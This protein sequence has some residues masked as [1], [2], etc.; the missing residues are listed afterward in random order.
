MYIYGYLKLTKTFSM[1]HITLFLKGFFIL[2][3]I[4][5]SALNAQNNKSIQFKSG[6]Y[7]P[8]TNINEIVNQVSYSADELVNGN[9]YRIIQFATIP[10][11]QQKEELKNAG[12]ELLSYLPKNAFYASI[13]TAANMNEL[14]LKNA[15]SVIAVDPIFK[16]NK[17]LKS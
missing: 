15:L 13:S 8:Q 7:I 5:F 12:I 14:L 9:Y 4:S 17:V 6:N 16:L 1:K 3:I 2:L 11:T 10:S